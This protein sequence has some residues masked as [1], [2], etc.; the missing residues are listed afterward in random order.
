M[1]ASLSI[2]SSIHM[3]HVSSSIEDA[4]DNSG[5]GIVVVVVVVEDEEVDEEVD[6]VPLELVLDV[7]GRIYGNI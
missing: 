5:A 3:V 6:E 7:R 4:L 1:I 2:N